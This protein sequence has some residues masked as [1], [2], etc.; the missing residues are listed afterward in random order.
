MSEGLSPASALIT[1]LEEILKNAQSI[2][3]SIEGTKE[4][5]LIFTK[6]MD[7]ERVKKVLKAWKFTD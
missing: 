1:A 2:V 6:G 3:D 7:H 5:F 4:E